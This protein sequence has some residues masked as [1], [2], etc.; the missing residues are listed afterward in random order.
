LPV[1]KLSLILDETW[2]SEFL[3]V[4]S[5]VGVNFSLPDSGVAS[6]D[7]LESFIRCVSILSWGVDDTMAVRKSL[8]PGSFVELF[9]SSN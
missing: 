7:S 2:L 6:L 1:F 4:S 8:E 9:S 3:R 5:V